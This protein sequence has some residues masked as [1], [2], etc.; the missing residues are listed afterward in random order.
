ML[1]DLAFW[2]ESSVREQEAGGQVL[3][4]KASGS[5][6]QASSYEAQWEPPSYAADSVV[7]QQQLAYRLHSKVGPT[8]VNR[9]VLQM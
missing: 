7:C 3:P 4:V 2:T 5:A 8:L 9:T 6:A 1:A